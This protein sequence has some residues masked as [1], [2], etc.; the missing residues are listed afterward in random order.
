MLLPQIPVSILRRAS[1]ECSAER[2]ISVLETRGPPLL[3]L[4]EHTSENS[5]PRG[6][7]D[8]RSDPSMNVP[9]GAA[10]L[11]I[12][13]SAEQPSKTRSITMRPEKG[14]ALCS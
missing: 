5:R 12:H 6:G 2:L 11:S 1:P 14:T 4:G 7:D 9:D 13:G 8:A 10:L 3:R